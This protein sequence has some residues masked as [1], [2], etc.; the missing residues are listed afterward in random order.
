MQYYIKN[1]YT[2][3][4]VSSNKLALLSMKSIEEIY[5]IEHEEIWLI[6]N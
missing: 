4:N 6:T 2:K 3:L 1:Q 5:I